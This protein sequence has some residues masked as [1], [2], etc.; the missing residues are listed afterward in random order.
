M[1]ARYYY[2]SERANKYPTASLES[3]VSETCVNC[4][5]TLTK[6]EYAMGACVSCMNEGKSS[7]QVITTDDQARQMHDRLSACGVPRKHQDNTADSWRGAWPLPVKTWRGKPWSVYLH[8]ETGTGKTHVATSLLR[9]WVDESNLSVRW[10]TMAE[11]LM[12]LKGSSDKWADA[13]RY[14]SPKLLVLDE[15]KNEDVTAWER[16]QVVYVIKRRYEEERALVVTSN[17]SPVDLT[18]FEPSVVSRLA[19]G[20][21]V[22][23]EGPDYRLKAGR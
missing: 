21:V 2:S 15:L 17:A 14:I 1:S 6:Y 7:G 13:Q 3:T 9:Q 19:E 16:E 18:G 4:K 11:L 22:H 5:R 20:I 8:G 12:I 23:F 10:T